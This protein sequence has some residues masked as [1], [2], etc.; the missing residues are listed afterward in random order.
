[1]KN[2]SLSLLLLTTILTPNFTLIAE[3]AEH[4]SSTSEQAYF[5][6]SPRL[7]DSHTTFSGVRVR[8]A[9][10]Y[11]DL[12]IP[13][14]AVGSLQQV[15]VAQRQGGEEIKF[16][17]DKTRAFQGNHRRKQEPITLANVTQDDATNTINITFATPIKPGSKITIG[18]KPRRNPDLEGFY[19]FGV[20]A[21]PAGEEP[22]GLYLGVARFY[23]ENGSDNGLD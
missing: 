1:M 16:R 10:Y 6:R 19:L 7:V 4:Q 8:Q 3:A 21:F 20:T 18:L 2:L 17:I 15:S 23:F 11:F 13:D 9:V 12:E 5:V 22:I 14:D